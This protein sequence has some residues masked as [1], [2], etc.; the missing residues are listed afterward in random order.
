MTRMTPKRPD[1]ALYSRESLAETRMKGEPPLGTHW[2]PE[3]Q[4]PKIQ[5]SLGEELDAA[6]VGSGS[7]GVIREI[8]VLTGR[9]AMMYE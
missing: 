6:D 8:A 7:F 5:G 3:R 2:H 1:T 9:G 4:S